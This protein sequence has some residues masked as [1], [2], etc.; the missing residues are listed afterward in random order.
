[1]TKTAQIA[2]ARGVAESIAGSGV[3]VNSV[4]VGP[5]ASEGAGDFVQNLSRSRGVSPAQIEKEF[6]ETM[7]PSSLLKRFET[8]EEVAAIVAFVASTQSVGING[9]AVRADGGVLR[10]IL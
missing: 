5:T 4:L 2:I 10:S 8:T 6:F 1:M 3:T 7:R 9:A